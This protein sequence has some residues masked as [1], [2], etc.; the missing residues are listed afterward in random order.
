MAVLGHVDHGKTTLLDSIRKTSIWE[1]EEGGVTQ[2]ISWSVVTKET[3][4]ITFIDT[5]G[6]E[7]FSIMREVGG[8]IADIALLIIASDDGVQ[9]QTKEAIQILKNAGTEIIVVIT[10]MDLPGADPQKIRQQLSENQIFVEGWG[11][12]TPIVEIS[13]KTGKGIDELLEMILLVAELKQLKSDNSGNTLGIVLDNWVDSSRGKCAD[14]IIVRGCLNKGDYISTGGEVERVGILFDNHG[15]QVDMVNEGYGVRLM[16]LKNIHE[17]GKLV[18][19]SKEQKNIPNVIK[20]FND[21][22]YEGCVLTCGIR[23]DEKKIENIEDLFITNDK[24]IIEFF[25]KA[26]TQAVLDAIV[27]EI[28]Q[29]SYEF[30]EIR[31]MVM[32]NGVGNIVSRD[33]ELAFSSNIKQIFGF[34]VK[35]DNIAQKKAKELGIEIKVYKIIYD[36]ILDIKEVLKSVSKPLEQEEVIGRATVKQVFTLSDNS[37]IAGC[38]VIEGKLIKGTKIKVIRAGQEININKI[39]SLRMLKDKVNSV[40]QGS[41]CGVGLSDKFEIKEGDEIINIKNI[42]VNEN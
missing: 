18:Y 42:K 15:K 36:I 4:D 39:D 30:D 20:Y 6:H 17:T 31:T 19:I 1:T 9:P 40:N 23:K 27:S 29:T 25:V 2:H 3:K 14:L 33:V 16:S 5:P 32:S 21:Y 38:I 28:K 8:K 10:K 22:A 37:V 26:D 35:V 12:N 11:G 7:A 34:N 41:E 13:A 24:K